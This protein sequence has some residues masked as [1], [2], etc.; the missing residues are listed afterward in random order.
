MKLLALAYATALSGCVGGV[1]LPQDS[2]GAAVGDFALDS[3][4]ICA[5][6]SA[7]LSGIFPCESGIPVPMAPDWELNQNLAF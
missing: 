2:T 3:Q 7:R 5:V 6:E 1:N 4:V